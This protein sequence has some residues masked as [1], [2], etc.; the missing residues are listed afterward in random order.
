M[1]R[2]E[3][4]GKVEKF[5]ISKGKGYA[6][7]LNLVIRFCKAI[8]TF[9]DCHATLVPISDERVTTVALNKEWICSEAF[10]FALYLS[11]ESYIAAIGTKN[12]IK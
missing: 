12:T 4:F 11:T 1:K 7:H 2:A 10:Y 5:S 8:E 6:L 3:V 9:S